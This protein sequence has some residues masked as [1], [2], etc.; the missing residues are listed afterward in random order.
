M[1][2]VKYT[3]LE[4][5]GNKNPKVVFTF[6]VISVLFLNTLGQIKTTRRTNNIIIN[7]QKI[8]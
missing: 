2:Q 3:T 8:L 7:I 4:H 6:T 5:K 1:S